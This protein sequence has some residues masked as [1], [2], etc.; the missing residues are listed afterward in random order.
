MEAKRKIS[1]L[2]LGILCWFGGGAQAAVIGCNTDGTPSVLAVN[3]SRGAYCVTDFGWSNT[4]YS[5]GAD[6]THPLPSTYDQELDLFSGDD[7]VNLGFSIFAGSEGPVRVTEKGWLTPT[8]DAGALFPFYNTG[9]PWTVLDPVHYTNG[10]TATQ[11]TITLDLPGLGSV[12]TIIDTEILADGTVRQFY[13][14]QNN[15]D[16][17]LTD[18]TFADYFNFHP[19]G[20]LVA[21][22]QEGTTKINNG[23][24][25]TSGNRSLPSFIASG[26]MRLLDADGNPLTPTRQDIGCA[27]ILGLDD[28][29]AASGGPTIPRVETGTYNNLDGPLGPGDFAGA[30]AFDNPS[31]LAPGDFITFGLEKRAIPEPTLMAL[32]GVGLLVFG[33]YRRKGHPRSIEHRDRRG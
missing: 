24:V 22:T 8:L 4:W 25:T 9:S 10:E 26:Q 16:G 23:V 17:F 2:Y 14:I 7:A 33:L 27:D 32:L 3:N 18:I 28:S 5:V 20:S 29:C 21:E 12:N 15:A 31:D 19:N 11:S 13:T 1:L 6:G 30:L